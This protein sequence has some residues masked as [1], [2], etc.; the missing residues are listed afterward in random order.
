[1]Y[2]KL[3]VRES[4]DHIR[5]REGAEKERRERYENLRGIIN[6]GESSSDL[7]AQVRSSR[8]RYRTF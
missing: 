8:E 7:Y 6:D 1:M 3:C 4:L 5:K 2:D